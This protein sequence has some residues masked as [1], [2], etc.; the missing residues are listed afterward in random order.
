MTYIDIRSSK[1]FFYSNVSS[2]IILT[3]VFY[4]EIRIS[5]ENVILQHCVE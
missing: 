2:F 5:L 1:L 4:K 3:T